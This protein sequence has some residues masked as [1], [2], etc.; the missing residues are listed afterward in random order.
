MSFQVLVLCTGNI[1]R[2]PAGELLLQHSLGDSVTVRS[3]GTHALVGN[4]IEPQMAALLP[5]DIDTDGFAARQLG[6]RMLRDADL[7]LP[8]TRSHR[9]VA[10]QEY[11]AA[12]KRAF[13]FVE[14]ARLLRLPEL[15]A[16]AASPAEFLA[17]AVPMAA[18]LRAGV[19]G[20]DP[21]AD[22]VSDPYRR[23]DEAFRTAYAD[24]HRAT[25]AIADAAGVSRPA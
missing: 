3:A 25:R 23:G 11:P 17:E 20:T 8:M 5:A 22:D 4:P 14:F 15:T 9:E 16:T 24:I 19:R 6:V 10:L 1:C 18:A 21:R 7:I 12:L 13:T 2:S